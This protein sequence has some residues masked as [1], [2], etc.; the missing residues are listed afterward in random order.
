[1]HKLDHYQTLVLDCDGVILNSNYLKIDAYF[2]TARNFGANEQQAQALVDY[3]IKL[4]GISRFVKFQYFLSDIL[5]QPVKQQDVDTLLQDF[6]REV[7]TR[8]ASCE[9]APGLAELRAATAAANWLVISGG[10]QL[11]LRDIFAERGIADWFDG[12]IFGSPDNKD[13]I[14]ARELQAG[15][16][17]QL[18]LFLGDSRYD[19]QASTGAGLDFVFLHAWTD[20]PQ[21]QDYCAQHQITVRANI[22]DVLKQD[23]I[24]PD[25]A[26][27]NLVQQD[28]PLD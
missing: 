13:E 24:Q 26:Q 19:H 7:R 8:L 11:E 15:N 21:W 16:I 2:A 1:M 23:Q 14:L 3:H 9:I 28:Q 22:A 10:D 20:V 6:G 4:G 18:A 12:G 25:L 27:Q 5:Q 17:R